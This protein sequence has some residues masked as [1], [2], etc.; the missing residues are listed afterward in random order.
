M[1]ATRVNELIEEIKAIPFVSTTFDE[2]TY[3]LGKVENENDILLINDF[4]ELSTSDCLKS[5]F[6]DFR[7]I[8]KLW[9]SPLYIKNISDLLQENLSALWYS[10]N[11][12]SQSDVLINDV[13]RYEQVTTYQIMY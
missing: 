5:C 9:R 10:I 1:K 4:N 2:V 13:E 8:W 6:L 7:V 12:D 11:R 3:W